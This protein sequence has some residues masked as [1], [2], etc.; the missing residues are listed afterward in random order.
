MLRTIDVQNVPLGNALYVNM[1]IIWSQNFQ[2]HKKRIKNCESKYVL[3]KKV[4]VHATTAKITVTKRYMHL[5]HEC[6]KMANVLVK[7]LVTVC[8]LPIVFWIL[9]QH[10]TWHQKFDILFLVHYKIQI[11]KL[12]LR[13]D[14]TSQWEKKVNYEYKCA[15]I[16]ERHSLQHYTTYFW[17]QTYATGF[18]IINLIIEKPVA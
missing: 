15:T 16:T 18:S 14:I 7:H 17:N 8:N 10:A 2:S 9:E 13:T 1:K 5:W 4:I 3:M 6:M 12:K 11:N